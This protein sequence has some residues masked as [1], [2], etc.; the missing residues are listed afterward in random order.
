MAI[1]AVKVAQAQRA[2]RS[3]RTL[4]TVT[5]MVL[6]V[7]D[8]DVWSARDTEIHAGDRPFTIASAREADGETTRE[9]LVSIISTVRGEGRARLVTILEQAGY[10]R[11]TLRHLQSRWPLE[12]IKACM[13]LGGMLSET[14][15]EPLL[16]VL[17]ADSDPAVRIAAA[18]AL[19]DLGLV[20]AIPELLAGVEGLTRWQR[21]RLANVLARVGSPAV[22]ALFTT[23]SGAGEAKTIFVLDIISDIGGV[24][25]VRPIVRLIK[26]GSP[27][28]RGRAVELLSIA[29]AVDALDVIIIASR[30]PVWFV[31]LRAVKAMERLGVP[32]REELIDPYYERLEALL[33]DEYWW[34][35]QR[36]ASALA[37]A[38]SRGR[39]I[40][41]A[42]I[43]DASKSAM[44]LYELRLGTHG[45]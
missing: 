39:E 7:L 40:L 5:G 37:R 33:N 20:A 3:Q 14:A 45:P 9:A 36:A 42:S 32:D 12:R 27:E 2:I 25:D 21:L 15:V 22:P 18:E 6:E 4:G 44:Q 34:V 11:A 19:A 29:G 28:V 16:H 30:D 24:E 38:H 13:I 31:R 26:D 35:R 10:V 23:L 43:S 1:V 17:D 41:T 8:S